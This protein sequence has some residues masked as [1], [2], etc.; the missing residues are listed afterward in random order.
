MTSFINKSQCSEVKSLKLTVIVDD[1]TSID[2]PNLLGKHGLCFLIEAT[3]ND[4]QVTLMVDT[5]PSSEVIQNNLKFLSVDL[6]KID[7]IILTHGHY[8]HTGGLIEVLKQIN[9]RVMILTH[10]KAFEPKFTYKPYL[11][12]VGM[13]FKLSSIEEAGGIVICARNSI[14]IANGIITSGEIERIV[15]Y[16]KI[17]DLWVIE[18]YK[19]QKDPLID[20]QAVIINIENKGLVVISGCA[21]S[22]IIN[23]LMHAQKVMNV[24]R[25][26]AVIGGF[27]LIKA[28]NE[29]IKAT[30][31]DLSN[32]NLE[33]IGPCH[34][35]GDKAIRMLSEFFG[36][37][38]KQLKTGDIIQL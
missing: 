20:D 13:P 14:N 24:N 22:G 16:E 6:N 23:T 17:E 3:L 8:D 21:H 38:C 11:K 25:V 29:R 28:T 12:F 27:H 36:E 9:R 1:S 19:F 10:P 32:F 34:C 33:F 2:N 5:G 37:R 30:L 18:D 4:K 7:Y 26:Y 35:T 15:N 31:N